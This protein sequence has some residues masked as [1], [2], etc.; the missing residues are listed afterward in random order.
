MFQYGNV[1]N[2]VRYTNIFH[3]LVPVDVTPNNKYIIIY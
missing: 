2:T 1:V 3:C